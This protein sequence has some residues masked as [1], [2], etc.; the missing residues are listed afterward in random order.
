MQNV[1]T[2]RDFDNM[3]HITYFLELGG[4]S[5]MTRNDTHFH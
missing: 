3:L 2:S 1:M 4:H 5:I